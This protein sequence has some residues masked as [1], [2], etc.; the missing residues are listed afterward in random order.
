MQKLCVDMLIIVFWVV[1]FLLHFFF[2][3]F[4]DNTVPLFF[5]PR[6]SQGR[7]RQVEVFQQVTTAFLRAPQRSDLPPEVLARR[8]RIGALFRRLARKSLSQ[9]HDRNTQDTTLP[10]A[11]SPPCG[12]PLSSTPSKIQREELMSA[13]EE[14]IDCGSVATELTASEHLDEVLTIVESSVGVLILDNC[15]SHTLSSSSFSSPTAD[16]KA[17]LVSPP[18]SV[19]D[20][21]SFDRPPSPLC[22]LSSPEGN[23][24]EIPALMSEY[25]CPS[26]ASTSSSVR[27]VGSETENPHL[28]SAHPH[29]ASPKVTDSGCSLYLPTIFP[30]H[31]KISSPSDPP[32]GNVSA[33]ELEMMW[34]VSQGKPASAGGC[35]ES[36]RLQSSTYVAYYS[37]SNFRYPSPSVVAP[38]NQPFLKESVENTAEKVLFDSLD[39]GPPSTPVVDQTEVD[40]PNDITDSVKDSDL[41]ADMEQEGNG[42]NHND[43]TE[44]A[45]LNTKSSNFLSE[46]S[47]VISEGKQQLLT[48]SDKQSFPNAKLSEFGKSCV[49]SGSVRSDSDSVQ[50]SHDSPDVTPIQTPSGTWDLAEESSCDPDTWLDGPA[51]KGGVLLS[52]VLDQTDTE[53]FVY[54][55]E[56]IQVSLCST[57]EDDSSYCE[58]PADATNSTSPPDVSS[59]PPQPQFVENNATLIPDTLSSFILE[60]LTLPSAT[61]SLK[62]SSSSLPSSLSSHIAHRR[63]VPFATRSTSAVLSSLFALDTSTPFRA[64]QSWTQLQLQRLAATGTAHSTA[65]RAYVRVHRRDGGD[66]MK[67]WRRRRPITSS[68]C[69]QQRNQDRVSEK[70]GV[71]NIL[72]SVLLSELISFVDSTAPPG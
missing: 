25:S 1:F 68:V 64:V 27:L 59:L 61:P 18:P 45:D 12:S 10:I 47:T 15:R 44:T 38:Q 4:W 22:H 31:P 34:G 54:W 33:S 46:E 57:V 21:L 50:E 23:Y 63:D 24:L 55:A 7:F 72:V 71:G 13:H 16:V 19:G 35:Q 5:L 56:P 41:Q 3:N 52:D 66:G 36:T 49:F 51:G 2:G 65:R 67:V 48:V 42:V 9:M 39:N 17:P 32:S 37:I 60:P 70:Q 14:Q 11:G 30:G 20:V 29:A 40:L 6:F 26:V 28:P 43:L 58:A 69:G 62:F 53:G 8:R